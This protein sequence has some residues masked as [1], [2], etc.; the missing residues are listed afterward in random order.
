MI[1]QCGSLRRS[2]K[3]LDDLPDQYA[4]EYAD[5]ISFA[6]RLTP[7][8][9]E[10]LHGNP[11]RIKRFLNDL[12]V[13]QS[14][15]SR[16]GIELDASIVAKLMALEQLFQEEFGH[17]IEWLATGTLRQRLSELEDVAGRATAAQP[18]SSDD[19]PSVAGD[20][21]PAS[22]TQAKKD[23][24][25]EDA[26]A[27]FSEA[28]LRW[29]KLPPSL[30]GLELAPYLY[31]AASFKGQ[32][33]L[34]QGLPERL[35][36]VASNLL[37]SSRADRQAVTDADLTALPTVDAEELISHLGRLIRDQPARQKFGVTAMLRMSR[38]CRDGAG[39]AAKALAT[40]PVEEID[41]G[42]P[43][44]VSPTDDD[45]I[46]KVLAFWKAKATSHQLKEAIKTV[47]SSRKA[48]HGNE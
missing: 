3:G 31:L 30:L 2:G 14:V 47:E 25:A 4:A 36:D 12:R 39:Y 37:S 44:L 43:L 6:A 32:A 15:A 40:L 35:R 19:V 41:F 7:L 46:Y 21:A 33:L 28:M 23:S 8:L 5:E 27:R 11:R 34:D 1:E 38:F 18:K 45:A 29:A 26:N 22:K 17:V 9:Y 16:R 20:K 48:T 13:R 24:K 42:T 10:K